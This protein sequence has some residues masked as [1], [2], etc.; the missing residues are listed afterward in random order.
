MAAVQAEAAPVADPP[1][2]EGRENSAIEFNFFNIEVENRFAALEKVDQE[3]ISG[4]VV[5]DTAPGRD[6]GWRQEKPRR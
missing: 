3:I 2:P 5:R 6:W 1:Q 4:K